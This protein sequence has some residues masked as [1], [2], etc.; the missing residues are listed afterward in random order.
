MENKPG[1][2]RERILAQQNCEYSEDVA[3]STEKWEKLPKLPG[4]GEHPAGIITFL[5]RT[6]RNHHAEA[7][8]L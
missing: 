3:E 5:E 7:D 4:T 2:S 6:W 8:E 1:L